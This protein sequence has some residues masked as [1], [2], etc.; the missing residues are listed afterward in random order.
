MLSDFA[1]SINLATIGL[2]P[3]KEIINKV[4]SQD[5]LVFMFGER[6]QNGWKVK[7]NEQLSTCEFASL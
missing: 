7:K 2:N 4:I 1:T 3:H 5:E 6:N